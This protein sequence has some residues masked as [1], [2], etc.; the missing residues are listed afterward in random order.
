MKSC[1]KI[2]L[3]NQNGEQMFSQ[4]ALSGLEENLAATLAN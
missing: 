2:E 4:L 3:A 1:I